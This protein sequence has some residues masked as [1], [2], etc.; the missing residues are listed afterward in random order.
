MVNRVESQS[1]Y[2]DLSGL[3]S[4]STLGR[5][6]TPEALH[7]V[8][9]QFESVFLNIM[10]KA[11]RDSNAVFSEG[12]YLSSNETEFHQQ[13]F[14]NQLS[15]SLSEG[16][17]LG[18]A[19]ILYE[20][21]M[22]QYGESGTSRQELAPPTLDDASGPALQVRAAA[23]PQPAV[24]ASQPS[25]FTGP[26][27]QTL[28][29]LQSGAK[30]FGTGAD[31]QSRS[32][33]R[34]RHIQ[35]PKDFVKTLYP[36]AEQVASS[37]GVDP[38]VL[39]AQSALETGW[40]RKMIAMPDGSNSHNLFGIKADAR[41]T[42]EQATVRTVE[43][44]DGVAA[45]EKASFRSYNSYEE[46]FKDYVKFL[47][48]NPRYQQALSQSHDADSFTQR[49]QDAGYATDP[50]YAKKIARVMNSKTMR[51]ALSELQGVPR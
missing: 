26:L 5:Q 11:M 15:L 17:G 9:Q 46:S 14:D 16:K 2:T 13:N 51:F 24:A 35:S 48:E 8:A 29:Q 38:R 20:Q 27:T 31:P 19:D 44:R 3:N 6:N 45:L 43:Y 25:A 49:L 10:L 21:M 18:L 34:A 39:L 47:Q 40:G 50:V 12:N 32:F 36:I 28:Q 37:I 33:A 41:W 30:V 42:G 22:G 4:I 23:Q 1:V 7:K